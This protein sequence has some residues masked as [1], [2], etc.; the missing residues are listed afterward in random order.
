MS[1]VNS[2]IEEN[3]KQRTHGG[4]SPAGLQHPDECSWSTSGGHW[5]LYAVKPNTQGTGGGSTLHARDQRRHSGCGQHVSDGNC[6]RE[7]RVAVAQCRYSDSRLLQH[8]AAGLA[9]VAS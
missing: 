9:A 7:Q 6:Y 8:V 4:L 1:F 5:D 3:V 2:T